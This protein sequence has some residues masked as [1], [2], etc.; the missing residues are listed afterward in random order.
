[1]AGSLAELP[2]Q[3]DHVRLFRNSPENRW[4][5]RVH[6]QI[7]PA[8]RRGGGQAHWTDVVIHHVGYVDPEL[9]RR[10]R[11]RDLRLLRLELRELNTHPFTLFNLGSVY[12][13]MGQPKKA[14]AA[15]RLSIKKSHPEDS[16]TRK[17][18][19]LVSGCHE[20]LRQPEEALR[21]CLEGLTRCPC[22][23]ELL[24]REAGL[25]EGRNDLRGAEQC[26]RRLLESRRAESFSSVTAGLRTFQGHDRLARVLVKQ[27]RHG[28]AEYHWSE[29]VQIEPKFCNAW[30]GLTEHLLEQ[31]RWTELEE[32]L[33]RWEQILPGLLD[34]QVIRARGQLARKEFEGAR[35]LL[36]AVIARAPA[37]L[38]PRLVL[39]QLLL[40]QG[41]D[42][43]AAEQT[44]R[45]VLVLA[46][47]HSESRQQLEALLRQKKGCA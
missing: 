42:L 28:E 46:P 2:T 25:R 23:P 19:A 10:K 36:E 35:R 26:L 20:L 15:L 3:V 11:Q 34:P 29:A 16:I 18:Y 5:H 45:D 38:W 30:F 1:V 6:E 17:L 4:A 8:I 39:S 24:F 44:L 13:D 41:S 43:D 37:F 32:A 7:L 12:L 9:R 22:D 47:H 40:E 27:G 14:L 31:A 21:A 33:V